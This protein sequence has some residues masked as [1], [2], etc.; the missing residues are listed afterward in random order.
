MCVS[1]W[2]YLVAI[3]NFEG[4]VCVCISLQIIHQARGLP[5][6]VMQKKFQENKIR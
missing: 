4:N 6:I 1:A 5:W 3:G 2:E